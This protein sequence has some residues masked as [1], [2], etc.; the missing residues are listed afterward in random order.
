[1]PLFLIPPWCSLSSFYKWKFSISAAVPLTFSLRL[2]G[3]RS[4]QLSR[5]RLGNPLRSPSLASFL[6][7]GLRAP[8]GAL[9]F[10]CVLCCFTFSNCLS[11]FFL[12]SLR[13]N[14]HANRY[15]SLFFGQTFAR[16][17]FCDFIFYT[18][19]KVYLRYER[20]RFN[21]FPLCRF[22]H[23]CT[24]YFYDLFVVTVEVAE[25]LTAK[26]KMSRHIQHQGWY[27]YGAYSWLTVL[28]LGSG[29]SSLC[30]GN[31]GRACGKADSSWP[32]KW[33]QGFFN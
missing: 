20:V 29:L 27:F 23:F 7:P 13:S 30:R 21:L 10:H 12:F 31:N 11:T 32:R 17:L 6:S 9:S 25:F 2:F 5:R 24:D 33:P 8:W 14:I 22:V 15:P 28:T 26:K 19:K 18:K 3:G 16:D 1:M 4:S